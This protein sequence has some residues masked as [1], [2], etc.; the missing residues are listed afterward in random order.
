[1]LKKLLPIITMAVGAIF[2]LLAIIGKG[3]ATGSDLTLKIKPANYIMP[4]AYKVYANPD[5][6]G[7]RFN[8]FKAVLKNTS[9]HTVRNLKVEYRIPKFINDWTE[10]IAPK[11]V[12]PGQSVVVLAY[13]AF[14]QSI[15]QKNSQSKEKTEI[16]VTFGDKSTPVEIDE[17]FTFTMMAAED[18]AYTDMPASELVSIDD[19]YENAPLYACFVTSEDP[20]IQ[21]YTS[22]IQQKL[23][24][25]ETAVEKTAEQE[26]RF[27]Q[28]IYEATRLSGM[29]Y[30]STSGIPAS[31][32]DVTTMVQRIRI[33]REV[34]TGNTGLCIELSI[35]YASVMRSAGLDAIIFLI[36]GHAFPGF[37]L[38]GQ[39]FAIE[40]TAIGGEGLGNI[41]TADEALENGMKE[42]QEAVQAM[43]QGRQ[44]YTIVDITELNKMG[45]IP[46]ELQD[47]NFSRQKIDE[48]AA[49]WD[50]SAGRNDNRYAAAGGGG[51]AGEGGGGNAGGGGN[52]GG[53]GGSSSGGFA[54]YN[55]EVSFSYPAG[56]SIAR[57]PN[58]QLPPLK[59]LITSPQGNLEV[60]QIDGAS[61]VGDGLNY[62]ARLYGSMG[63]A[64]NYQP[65]GS[66]NGYTLISGMTSNAYGQR[67]GWYGAFRVKGS[68]VTGLV[69]P[70]GVTQASQ[71]LSTLR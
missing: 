1:M 65:T 68:S 33:P 21:Y 31:I 69:I 29:V 2:I 55:N 18:M 6:L 34:V 25:G 52:S 43:Q 28:G 58:P 51:N 70:A 71:I 30:S 39:Y 20:V 47:N 32:G 13:P 7:G 48:Y 4:A 63:L 11:Y 10:A 9:R 60:Y 36:P 59:S 49:L 61:S 40:A 17:S 56:W 64:I 19:F 12:L 26:L 57:N 41:G 35:L 5:V 8:L 66:L 45:V 62:L 67:A 15:T 16:R 14:D 37:R 50:K 44:G 53:G 27:L 22:R 38:N 42:M 54:A 46:M 23:L 24:K 3:S